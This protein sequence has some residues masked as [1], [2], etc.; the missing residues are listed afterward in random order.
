MHGRS[1][2]FAVQAA[3]FVVA[4]A[5]TMIAMWSFTRE[6]LAWGGF[7]LAIVFVALAVIVAARARDS[8]G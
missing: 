8:A 5:A 2:T 4:F 7:N 6:Q 3:S 1:S